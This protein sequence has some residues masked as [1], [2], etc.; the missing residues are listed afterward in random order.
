M[1]SCLILC[2]CNKSDFLSSIPFL[3]NTNSNNSESI[4]S[5][6]TTEV[7]EQ[8]TEYKPE[9]NIVVT[10][11]E[12]EIEINT[13]AVNTYQSDQRGIILLN[14]EIKGNLKINKVEKLGIWDFNNY[15]AV[16]NGVKFS[17]AIN[18]SVDMSE[19]ML[20]SEM[21]T[22]EIEPVLY[23]RENEVIGGVADIGWSGF[24]TSSELYKATPSGTVEVNLQPYISNIDND[25]YI[26]LKIR[27]K[28]SNAEFDEVYYDIGLLSNAKKGASLLRLDKTK[29]IKSI[30]GAVYD[31]G[32]SK[33]YFDEHLV[34][35]DSEKE[36]Y[37][38]FYDIKYFID[39]KKSP[40]KKKGT[41][42][43]EVA[44]FD[45][46]NKYKLNTSLVIGVQGDTDDSILYYNNKNAA[47]KIWNDDD[48]EVTKYVT[49]YK[50]SLTEGKVGGLWINRQAPKTTTETPS[51]ARIR[52]EFPEEADARTDA[53][54]LRFNGRYLVYQVELNNRPLKNKPEDY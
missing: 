37:A 34:N 51:Y 3:N 54:K 18:I 7:Q 24:S 2:S 43:R 1:V 10:E 29:R 32:I 22:I 31:I 40:K 36:E 47:W 5:E 27:D 52:I 39:Y 11:S 23:N 42:I 53:E 28:L 19:L 45:S 49:I 46:F 6:S 33:A 35:L 4:S 30:N 20:S 38:N 41:T 8:T 16:S 9:P 15:K 13:N 26:G 12:D 48:D 44:N 50:K 17:Y 25:C 14:G 21:A